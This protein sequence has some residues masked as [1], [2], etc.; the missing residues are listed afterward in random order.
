MATTFH[1]S[2][3]GI[4][5][6]SGTTLATTDALAVTAGDL[7][8]VDLGWEGAAGASVTTVTDGQSNTYTVANALLS[9]S[10]NDLRSV[11]YKAT[12]TSTG[13][14]NPSFTIDAA[15]T[16]RSI[17]AF[18]ATPSASTTLVIDGAGNQ[19]QGTSSTPSAGSATPTTSTGIAFAT[20]RQYGTRT[21]TAGS[22]WT[23]P[24]ELAGPI[25]DASHG[26]Y[27]IISSTSAVTGDL[28]L[29]SSN[30]FVAHISV[31]KEQASGGGGG[32][33]LMGQ[34]CL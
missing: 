29:D 16:F 18:S 27:R 24:A 32:L 33:T 13:T 21:A 25:A 4:A 7:I 19:A 17:T 6:A 14:I 20:V 1:D 15:R 3:I 26:E 11:T 30:E 22:G 12:A 31:F 10:N 5:S 8:Y 34:A 28:S 2:A 9:H 23:L